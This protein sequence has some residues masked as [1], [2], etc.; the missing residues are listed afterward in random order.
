MTS[1]EVK[2]IHELKKQLV[3]MQEIVDG[4]E[5]F[6]QSSRTRVDTTQAVIREI[7]GKIKRLVEHRDNDPEIIQLR[8]LVVDLENHMT[9]SK[10]KI[11]VWNNRKKPAWD[12]IKTTLTTLETQI[13]DQELTLSPADLHHYLLGE[14]E[15]FQK[16]Q[17][18]AKR[19]R[20]MVS[21]TL[22]TVFER[23]KTL[24]QI[25]LRDCK[26]KVIRARFLITESEIDVEMRMQKRFMGKIRTAGREERQLKKCIDKYHEGC[27]V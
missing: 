8:T 27:V 23:R 18:D 26:W 12:A 10:E 17:V 4:Q 19:A 7:E 24:T 1:S 16:R 13:A 5:E 6:V 11:Q 3:R 9:P 14:M 22:K 2:A 25:A 21:V 20:N 15:T